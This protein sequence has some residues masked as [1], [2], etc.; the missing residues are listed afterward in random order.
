MKISGRQQKRPRRVT[1]AAQVEHGE[2]RHRPHAQR[3]GGAG[4]AREGRGQ[5]THAGRDRHG[6][7]ERV[8]DDERRGRHV[9][10]VGAQVGA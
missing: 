5:L 8:V 9:A 7:G 3:H 4:Q 6:H 10:G 1:E 2:Q